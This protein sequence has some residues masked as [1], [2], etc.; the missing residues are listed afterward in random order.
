MDPSP[1]RY[2][3]L[4][5]HHAPGATFTYN[6]CLKVIKA[7]TVLKEIL[8]SG[9]TD[10]ADCPEAPWPLCRDQVGALFSLS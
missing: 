7:V 1:T 6:L 10:S 8:A 5:W 4:C 3:H 2:C 9:V